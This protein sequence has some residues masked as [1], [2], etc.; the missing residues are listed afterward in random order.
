MVEITIWD[1]QHGSAAYIKTPN[2]RHI[3]VDLGDGENFSPLRTLK[4][5][6]IPQL[7]A[8][9]ITHPHRDH[10]DDILNFK[11]LAP[12]TLWTPRQLSELDI[13][14][15]NR[16][17]DA[18]IVSEYLA[19]RQDYS[20]P[21]PAGID[22]TIPSDFGGALFQFFSPKSCST[23]N[24]NNHSIVVVVA[25]ANLKVVIPGD[26][27]SPSWNE[28]LLDPKFVA[29]IRGTDVLLASHHGRDAGYS[30]E[31]FEVMGKPKLV[32][33]S[34]GRFGDTS[35]T[36][37]YSNQASGWTVY[38]AAGASDTRKCLTTR[39]DGHIA[40]NFGWSVN[41]PQ[42][43][44]VLNVTTSKVNANALKARMLSALFAR[45]LG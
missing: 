29:A 23:A 22:P 17:D 18:A 33:V 28:L 27:E 3:V 45:K 21:V 7:D 25:F 1:V 39:N 26:N 44:N 15:G 40:V 14:K 19:I 11:L 30:A 32:V 36:D 20:L 4:G 31:L 10:M 12:K 16:A 43:V 5:L 13:R 37:R 8:V 24:L 41:D 6:G 38:D 42:H 9:V 34:D 2:N 35:A